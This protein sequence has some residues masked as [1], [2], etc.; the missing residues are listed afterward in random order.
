MKM[1]SST[2]G[3]LLNMSRTWPSTGLPATDTSGFG[4]DHVW[5]RSRVPKPAVGITIFI[6]GMLLVPCGHGLVGLRSTKEHGLIERCA[7]E[8]HAD[9]QALGHRSPQGTQGR[10]RR[11][12]WQA[13]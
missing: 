9:R 12:G 4:L 13:A 10:E 3:R 11:R 7:Q 6:G 8:L 2:S 5:G 1:T